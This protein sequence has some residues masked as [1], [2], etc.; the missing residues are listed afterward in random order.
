MWPPRPYVDNPAVSREE[1]NTGK[2][3]LDVDYLVAISDVVAV[4]R[5][6]YLDLHNT[7]HYTA[8]TQWKI[9]EVPCNVKP[10]SIL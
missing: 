2:K 4:K 9:K 8:K 1:E 7:V 3:S 10:I 6:G 5:I